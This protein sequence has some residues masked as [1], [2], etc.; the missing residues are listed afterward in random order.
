MKSF[1]H[2][3]LIALLVAVRSQQVANNRL[4]GD[5]TIPSHHQHQPLLRHQYH[6]EDQADIVDQASQGR[7]L[8]KK[9]KGGGKRAKESD[10]QKGNKGAKQGAQMVKALKKGKKGS[11]G[12]MS[13]SMSM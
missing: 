3:C 8:K 9:M 13:M 12:G 2:L 4:R 5:R 11:K 1:F 7:H 10:R 6:N